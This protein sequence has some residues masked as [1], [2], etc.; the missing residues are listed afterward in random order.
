MSYTIQ[1]SLF[2]SSAEP[3]VV[4]KMELTETNQLKYLTL[5]TEIL[6][7]FKEEQDITAPVL[8]ISCNDKGMI[9]NILNK[10]NYAYIFEL[11]KCYFITKKITGLNNIITLYLNE[12]VLTTWKEEIYKLKPLVTRQAT[13]YDISLVDPA[14]PISTTPKV[15]IVGNDFLRWGKIEVVEVGEFKNITYR[16]DVN[17][18]KFFS[19]NGDIVMQCFTNVEG[20][21]D[22]N[23]CNG[24][25]S[26][27]RYYDFSIKGFEQVY[28]EITAPTFWQSM[29]NWFS[30]FSQAIM[31]IQLLPYNIKN[32]SIY[33]FTDQ[34]VVQF[35]QNAYTLVDNQ[36]ALLPSPNMY[37]IASTKIGW[38]FYKEK[39]ISYLSTYEVVL[40]Y[41]GKIELSPQLLSRFV[42]EN[43]CDLYVYLIINPSTWKGRYLIYSEDNLKFIT[44]KTDDKNEYAY[45]LPIHPEYIVY[46]SD[47]FNTGVSIPMGSTDKNQKNLGILTTGIAVAASVATGGIA[48]GVLG[49]LGGALSSSTKGYAQKAST[50]TSST[51]RRYY[52]EQAQKSFK[53]DIAGAAV[54]F[55]A[56]TLE[57]IIPLIGKSTSIY[58]SAQSSVDYYSLNISIETIKTEPQPVI[59][60]NY[61]ELYGGVCNITVELSTLKGKGFT[62]CANI[63]MTGFTSATLE[64]IN[65]IESLLLSGVIL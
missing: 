2:Q 50:D 37:F 49:A 32:N 12:D 31:D 43:A 56:N 47:E 62:K 18:D 48:G 26:S 38:T 4:N 15:T 39:F 30:D 54:S 28:K 14:I 40:P 63:H 61:Y 55:A 8:D 57:D 19:F 45:M 35:M 29:N 6:G 25:V 9:D 51:S 16:R 7:A 41:I 5:L 42:K 23:F 20:T 21:T 24:L 60:D 17:S 13:D 58:S 34:T 53:K 52:G 64:E 11:K 59:P 10:C 3:T 1:I 65:E 22:D 33:S 46:Q 36:K 44:K 27:N